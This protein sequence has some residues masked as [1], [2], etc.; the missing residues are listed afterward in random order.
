MTPLVAG[1]DGARGGWIVAELDVGNP[2]V[3]LRFVDTIAPVVDELRAGRF[4]AIAID[5]PIGLS[6]DGHRPVDQDARAR[7]GARRATFF[8]TP[9]RSVLKDDTWE[10]ANA[11]SRALSGKGLSK[12]AWNLV[13]KIREL[14]A[15]WSDEVDEV[16]VE[17]HPELSFAEMAGQPLETKKHDAAGQAER[18][19]LLT[20]TLAYAVR[21]AIDQCPRRWRGDAIDALALAWTARR[22]IADRAIVLGGQRDAAGRPMQLVI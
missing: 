18:V 7:L 6:E 17:A 5:M 21:P 11:R 22:L 9:I 20:A 4:S 2:A 10:D 8:P 15:A 1:V 19:D 12:Q 14:D 16:L 3:D 13:P